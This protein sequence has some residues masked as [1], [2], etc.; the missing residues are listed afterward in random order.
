[1]GVVLGQHRRVGMASKRRHSKGVRAAEQHAVDPAM[2]KRVQAELHAEFALEGLKATVGGIR[3]PRPIIS[4]SEDRTGGILLHQPLG[5]FQSNRRKVNHAREFAPLPPA[6]IPFAGT[7]SGSSLNVQY[8]YDSGGSSSN[9][10]RPTN[11]TYPNS[12][13]INYVYG[14]GM[15]STLN[16]VTNIQENASSVNL[17]TYTYL[18]LG[19][20]IRIDYSQPQVRL[21]LWGGTSGTFAGLDQFNRIVDQ[22]WLNYNTSTDLDRY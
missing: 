5:D 19:T 14:S 20:V 21:D 1:M 16:R 2:P 9:E 10:I 15:D 8:A 12:R 7:V 11:I 18:C 6:H 13:Q 3:C 22:R 4:I 17:A